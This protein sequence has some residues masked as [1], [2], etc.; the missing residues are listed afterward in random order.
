[1]LQHVLLDTVSNIANTFLLTGLLER[2]DGQLEGPLA[3]LDYFMF[4]Y[5]N[6]SIYRN[7]ML[8]IE[9]LRDDSYQCSTVLV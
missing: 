5:L 8:S 6:N 4:I 3:P 2:K 9:E 7:R 1:M